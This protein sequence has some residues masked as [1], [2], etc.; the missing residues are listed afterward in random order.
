MD[1]VVPSL[2][3]TD[4]LDVL[5]ADFEKRRSDWKTKIISIIEML[6][7]ME[8]L[9]ESQVLM[10][11]YRHILTD[12]M[13]TVRLAISRA[14]TNYDNAYKVTYRKY[15]QDDISLSPTE[16]NYMVKSDMTPYQR[17]IDIL[18]AYLEYLKECVN[19]LDNMGFANDRMVKITKHLS[20][21]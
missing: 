2:A 11:S 1:D 18:N 5:E 8:T 14:K 12:N 10:L 19:T 13:A 15:F 17:R 20:G 3:S 21:A 4:P 16:K 7:N 9:A 6:R